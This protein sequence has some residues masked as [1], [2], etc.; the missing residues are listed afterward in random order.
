[1]MYAARPPPEIHIRVPYG[2]IDNFSQGISVIC[3]LPIRTYILY[4]AQVHRILLLH[5]NSQID[6]MIDS[7]VGKSNVQSNL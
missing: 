1:M 4:T 6:K 2:A 7:L 5:S 3:Q